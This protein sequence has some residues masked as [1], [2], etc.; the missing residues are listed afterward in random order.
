FKGPGAMGVSQ[1]STSPW[2][3]VG[4]G[5]P[6]THGLC[7]GCGDK[8]RAWHGE[9][10]CHLGVAQALP[11]PGS[12]RRHLPLKPGFLGAPNSLL[13]GE[14]RKR[15]RRSEGHHGDWFYPTTNTAAS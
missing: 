12:K 15:R 13:G 11:P 1:L 8:L 6:S 7:R 9:I 14:P 4:W 5:S 2:G 3:R 10:S